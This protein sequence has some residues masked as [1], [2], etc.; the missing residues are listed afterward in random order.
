MKIL[1]P[2][3]LL[4]STMFFVVARGQLCRKDESM[5]R[6]YKCDQKKH[7]FHENRDE[8]DKYCGYSKY[9]ENIEVPKV[10]N[11]YD[12]NVGEIPY[13]ASLV[14]DGKHQCGGIII[15]N[16]HI[17]TA[18]HCLIHSIARDP[19]GKGIDPA[20]ITV[21]MGTNRRYI[22]SLLRDDPDI[23][24]REVEDWVTHEAY[25]QESRN[26]FGPFD[27]KDIG[28]LTLTRPIIFST[29]I[30]PVCIA[31]FEQNMGRLNSGDIVISGFG[32]DGRK[33]KLLLQV[34]RKLTLLSE[35]ECKRQLDNKY[36]RKFHDGMICSVPTNLI[37][38]SSACNGDSGGPLVQKSNGRYYL[39]GVVSYGPKR[40]RER[41]NRRPDVYTDVRFYEQWITTITER[42][43]DYDYYSDKEEEEEEEPEDDSMDGLVP[44]CGSA[45]YCFQANNGWCTYVESFFVQ[46]DGQVSCSKDLIKENEAF[47]VGG[48]KPFQASSTA[49][50]A[51]SHRGN[52]RKTIC[53]KWIFNKRLGKWR[54]RFFKTVDRKRRQA[55]EGNSN[56]G[57]STLICPVLTCQDKNVIQ[58]K[59]TSQEDYES[60]P[61][62]KTK[63]RTKV[64]TKSIIRA[65]KS[66]TP[67]KNTS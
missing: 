11:G 8:I 40:C 26:K 64:R 35:R 67:G 66:T 45:K 54:C 3:F 39:L 52:N 37:T 50:I 6:N 1:S 2:M 63:S 16:M 44:D 18:A 30:W 53:G 38:G 58:N 22:Q 65:D 49:A 62:L 19:I 59:W 28:I 10:V 57:G 51:V 34:G 36:K 41:Q 12:A 46:C 5:P 9:V 32:S 20:R 27:G 13:I 60:C 25:R 29:K 56:A 24:V 21:V 55:E 31:T 17:V 14:W 43:E 61:H 47:T 7:L 23:L 42:Y 15:D 33:T 48:R 4:L